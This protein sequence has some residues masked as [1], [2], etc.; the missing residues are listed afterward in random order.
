MGTEVELP[1]VNKVLG[2]LE[3]MRDKGG[4]EDIYKLGAELHM[5]VGDLLKVIRGAEQLQLVHTPGG[6]VVLNPLGLQISDADI[7]EKKRIIN[8]QLRQL[9]LFSQTLDFLKSQAEQAANR[10][11]LL[12]K[13]ADLYPTQNAEDVFA[14][15]I[16][17]G[18]FAE[19]FGYNDDTRTFYIDTGAEQDHE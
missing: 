3:V 12:E 9:S 19:L 6:D 10:D 2:L 8:R 17:W 4:R 14:Y 13:L 11:L 1:E 16:T 7:N 15:L 5:E 18:R